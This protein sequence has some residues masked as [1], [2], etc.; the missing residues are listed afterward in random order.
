MTNVDL[1]VHSQKGHRC[2]WTSGSAK[3]GGQAAEKR[4]IVRLARHIIGNIYQLPP[5]SLDPLILLLAVCGF[6]R[7]RILRGPAALGKS[8]EHDQSICA[9]WISS[10]ECGTEISPFRKAKHGGSFGPDRVHDRPQI[11]DPF[12][13]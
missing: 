7:P 12:F 10:G 13:Q 9:L 2:A 5:F 4:F 6:W 3:I 1:R 11:V 8:A